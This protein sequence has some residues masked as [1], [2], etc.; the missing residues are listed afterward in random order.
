LPPPFLDLYSRTSPPTPTTHPRTRDADSAALGR[1][2]RVSLRAPGPIDAGLTH[3]NDTH[4]AYD[5]LRFVLPHPRGELGWDKQQEKGRK[6]HRQRNQQLPTAADMVDDG[7]QPAGR[8][9]GAAANS[10]PRQKITAR[11]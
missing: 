6:L 4:P 3:I 8:A 9:T 5:A 7:A 10:S 2:I 1:D 11:E